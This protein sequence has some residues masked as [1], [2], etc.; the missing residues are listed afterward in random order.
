MFFMMRSFH[1][2]TVT[3]SRSNPKNGVMHGACSWSRRL[4]SLLHNSYLYQL[5][6]KRLLDSAERARELAAVYA[7]QGFRELALDFVYQLGASGLA[8]DT[9]RSGR[10]H[11][12]TT[13]GRMVDAADQPIG[14]EALDQLRNVGT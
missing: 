4:H 12:A 13:I 11:H 5:L 9:Q 1:D 8:L 14:F 3:T 6:K 10:R 7:R 2:V